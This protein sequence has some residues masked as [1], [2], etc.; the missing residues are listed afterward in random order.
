M[1]FSGYRVQRIEPLFNPLQALRIEFEPVLVGPELIDTFFQL[2]QRR[3][4]QLAGL[5]K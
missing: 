2:N 4:D 5:L 3:V 1:V